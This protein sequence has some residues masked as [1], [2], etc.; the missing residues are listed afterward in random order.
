MLF[1][2]FNSR[3]THIMKKTVILCSVIVGAA[4][5]I[6]AAEEKKQEEHAKT[7]STTEHKVIAP[8]DLKWGEMPPGLP[9][10]AKMAVL[11]G[12]PTK[13]GPFTVRMQASAGYKIFPHTHPTPERLTVISGTFRLGMG[14]KFDEAATQEMGPGSYIVLPPGMTHFVALTSESIV[15]ID[16]EGP[17]QIKYVNPADD[18]RNTKK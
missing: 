11:N 12:D 15:Q 3:N 5:F 7:A 4:A 13:A 1:E 10:G 17:F 18:P 9:A 16:S 2:I 8:S 14:D 6:I